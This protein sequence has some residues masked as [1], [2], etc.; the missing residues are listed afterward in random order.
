MFIEGYILDPIQ[1]ML[2]FSYRDDE[3]FPDAHRLEI[4]LFVFVLCFVWGVRKDGE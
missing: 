1:V 3:E 4:F 2:G